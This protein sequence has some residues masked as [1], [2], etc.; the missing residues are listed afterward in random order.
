MLQIPKLQ[1]RTQKIK[2]LDIVEKQNKLISIIV[3]IN[4]CLQDKFMRD[5]PFL[6]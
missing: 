6:A 3:K 4:I 1:Y 2:Y 5:V